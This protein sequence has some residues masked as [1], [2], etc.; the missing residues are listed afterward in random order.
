MNK[1]YFRLAREEMLLSDYGNG[2]KSR[3]LGCVVVLNGT[4]ISRGHNAMKTHPLQKIYNLERFE[5]VSTPARIHAEI[6]ALSP[7]RYI[8]KKALAKCEIY[9]Y[10]EL[11][12]GKKAMARPC[13]SCMKFIK[14][15][16]IHKIFYTT[17]DGYAKEIID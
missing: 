5:D 13:K 2:Q 9:V 15:L 8:E 14:K 17:N 16:G 11:K 12:S 4:V 10:R 7:I 1:H 6:A 3:C